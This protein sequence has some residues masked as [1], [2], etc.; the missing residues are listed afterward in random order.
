MAKS[1]YLSEELGTEVA[2]PSGYYQ[3]LEEG[4]VDH[5]GRRLLYTVGSACVEASCC[6]V[7]DWRYI[8]VEG[9]LVNDACSGGGNEERGMEIETVE[10]E[11]ERAAISKL[12]EDKHPGTRI[13]FR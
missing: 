12:L 3:P 13:E 11:N 5:Q 7:G 2:T 4:Y 8:R 9:Y 1:R 6:G 10:D